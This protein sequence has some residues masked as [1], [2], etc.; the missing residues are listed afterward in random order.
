MN[1]TFTRRAWAW[2]IAVGGCVLVLVGV[3]LL[4]SSNARGARGGDSGL[5]PPTK[6]PIPESAWTDDDVD[7]SQVPDFIPALDR[8]GDI[9]GYIDKM[10]ILGPSASPPP[11]HVVTGLQ[12]EPPIPVV[13]DDLETPVGYHYS[14]FGFVP[15]GADAPTFDERTSN[16]TVT[17]GGGT[18][19]M[20]GG[21]P[22]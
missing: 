12:P 19:E 3:A 8:T 22:E 17:Q 9:A 7:L 20:P 14:G 18:T 21:S 16:V 6:G 13:G 1:S 5:E 10:D 2:S 11:D 4:V 15:L